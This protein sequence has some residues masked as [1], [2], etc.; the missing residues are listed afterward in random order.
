MENANKRPLQ[1]L[2]FGQYHLRSFSAHV[3]KSR[4]EIQPLR[5]LDA[6]GKVVM[7]SCM[8]A[9]VGDVLHFD[10][11]VC[12]PLL[13]T[14]SYPLNVI[15]LKTQK[16][17][18]AIWGLCWNSFL[19]FSVCSHFRSNSTMLSYFHWCVGLMAV[20]ESMIYIRHQ[21]YDMNWMLNLF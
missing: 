15:P 7:Q 9:M 19:F 11:R 18:D 12:L 6:V 3:R 16:M 21:P 17:I 5:H 2:L 14:G 13:D 1:G 20:H 8:G 10:V 4:A